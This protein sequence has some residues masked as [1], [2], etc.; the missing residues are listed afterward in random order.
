MYK[1]Q[2]FNLYGRAEP[3]RMLLTHAKVEFEDV[4][5]EFADWPAIKGN[6]EFG[7]LP[8]VDITDAEGKVHQYT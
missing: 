6:F 7:Q 2:Y 3:I 8:A 1:V 5:Y 4:R